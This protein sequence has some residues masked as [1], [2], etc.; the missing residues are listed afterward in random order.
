MKRCVT[1]HTWTNPGFLPWR[2][3]AAAALLTLG[4]I[5]QARAM[6]AEELALARRWGAPRALARAL[7]VSGLAIGGNDGVRFLT[8]AVTT[9]AESPARLE[10]ARA[11][12]ELGAA[13][14]RSG[15]RVESR[16]PLRQGADLALVC[17]AEPL[18][19]R[20]RTELRA[21]GARPRRLGLSGPDALTPSER[22]IAQLAASG[23]SNR[24]IAQT[25]FLTAKTIEVHLTSTYQRLQVNGRH[26]LA[27]ALAAS[28]R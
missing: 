14:R 4:R 25:L 21:S 20:A 28:A 10:H 26:E 1:A 12:F 27:G 13:L 19:E 11:L 18:V 24:A 15:R 5:Q 17:G 2:S 7:T 8:E 9:A 16:E 23:Q 3:G 6:A 22:R